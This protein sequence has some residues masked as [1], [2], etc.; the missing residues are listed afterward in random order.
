MAESWYYV[1]GDQSVGPVEKGEMDSLFTQ[2]SLNKDSYVWKKGFENWKKA[3]D[4]DEF[5]SLFETPVPSFPEESS[6]VWS[7][8]E[9][10][11]VVTIKVGYDRGSDEAEFGPYTV[12]QLRR[13][14]QEKRINGKTFVFVPGAQNWKFLAD[15]PLFNMISDAMPPVIEES[16][17]RISRRKPFVAKLLFHDQSRVYEGICRDIS[18]G[19]LQIL[20]SGFCAKVGDAIKL[21]V[22][23]D[24]GDTCFSASGKV[25]RVLGGDQGI[26]LKFENLDE[27]SKALIH[28]YINS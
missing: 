13:A 25:V 22:H 19:G 24:N 14:F 2:G 6:D 18:V 5:R 28:R 11:Q 17:R 27:Q 12:R 15:T 26:S 23:P 10:R 4:T 21:N 7:V 1:Q 9:D 20:V 16:E 3:S 8:G